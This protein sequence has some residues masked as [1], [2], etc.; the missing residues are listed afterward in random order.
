MLGMD[1]KPETE[2]T[3]IL[4]LPIIRI[5]P[6]TEDLSDPDHSREHDD[7]HH[8]Y[9][10]KVVAHA[11]M[12][13]KR[14]RQL[15]NAVNRLPE[16]HVS[17][18]FYAVFRLAPI[19]IMVALCF[20]MFNTFQ[21]E[22][23][24]RQVCETLLNSTSTIDCNRFNDSQHK[25]LGDQ[26]KSQTA[27][28]QLYIDIIASV[29]PIFLA[30]FVG[31][32]SDIF[33]RKLPMVIPLLG[34]GAAAV[35]VSVLANFKFHPDL[36]LL[37]P[38]VPALTGG[39]GILLM[40]MYSF[41]GDYSTDKTRIVNLAVLEGLMDIFCNL[42]AFVGSQAYRS[43]G[44]AAPFYICSFLFISAGFYAVQVVHDGDHQQQVKKL[45]TLFSAKNFLDSFHTLRKPR[46]GNT[47]CHLFI[48]LSCHLLTMTVLQADSSVLQLLLQ[49]SPFN[50]PVTKF[51]IFSS[52]SGL[53]AAVSTITATL[54]LRK[55]LHLPDVV[56]CLLAS[57]SIIAYYGGFGLAFQDWMVY[58]AGTLGL[59]RGAVLPCT[60]SML[61]GM[62]QPNEIGKIL[63]LSSS[64]TSATP[65]CASL[66]FTTIFAAT[67]SWWPG[68]SFL[69][70]ACMI[71][72]VTVALFIVFL[73]RRRTLYQSE[74]IPTSPT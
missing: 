55:L 29:P 39:F 58:T 20:G 9:L 10:L 52:L 26:I 36:I 21:R 60:A 17:P 32:W 46:L 13:K 40:A 27:R 72:P 59:L 4:R 69:V 33:G 18:K 57:F 22:L 70:A 65:L 15:E 50:W 14:R 12:S 3:Q 51:A 41:V 62:V 44:I 37:Q 2:L 35:Y 71:V 42:G 61:A 73:V 16:L 7:S 53:L 6:A 19:T 11:P 43:F 31:S 24:K 49:F 23:I 1:E 5:D 45:S 8:E 34:M 68:L 30:P 67:G 48:L 47:R 66:I 64:L 25:D 38:V 63:S 54:L 74:A 28:Y 56:I